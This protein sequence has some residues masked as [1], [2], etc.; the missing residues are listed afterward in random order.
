MKNGL[1]ILLLTQAVACGTAF[2]A[3]N[4]FSGYPFN[5]NAAQAWDA[6][7]ANF[8]QQMQDLQNMRSTLPAAAQKELDDVSSAMDQI[9]SLPLT[10]SM[11]IQDGKRTFNGV[12]IL[13][14]GPLQSVNNVVF[15]NGKEIDLKTGKYKIG[16]RLTPKDVSSVWS[17]SFGRKK[18]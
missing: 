5:A 13:E 18:R 10:S 16:S 4:P 17:F 14:E 7:W 6:G 3:A 12:A 8:N 2:G 11:S 15:V 9:A 1:R